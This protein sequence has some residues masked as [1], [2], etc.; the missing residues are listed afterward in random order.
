MFGHTISCA[1]IVPSEKCAIAIDEIRAKAF[2]K[3]DE[4]ELHFQDAKYIDE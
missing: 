1:D 4:V 2:I 3:Y